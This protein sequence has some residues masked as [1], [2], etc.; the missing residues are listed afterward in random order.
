MAIDQKQT[1]VYHT[2]CVIITSRMIKNSLPGSVSEQVI[3]STVNALRTAA[4]VP[5]PGPAWFW[6]SAFPETN[7]LRKKRTAQQ[8]K[9][10]WV[11]IPPSLSEGAENLQVR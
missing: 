11:F 5:V 8:R 6:S 4:S 10:K 1:R 9:E 7:V 3:H 2:G